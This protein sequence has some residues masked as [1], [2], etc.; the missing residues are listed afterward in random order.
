[1]VINRLTG[2]GIS[3]HVNHDTTVIRG[4][5]ITNTNGNG[6]SVFG[7]R[8]ALE[9]LNNTFQQNNNAG[10]GTS[11]LVSSVNYYVSF[12][13]NGN[14]FHNNSIKKV[15][16][17]SIRDAIR[18]VIRITNNEIV[19][20]NCENL[21]DVEYVGNSCFPSS[22]QT[23]VLANN[24]LSSNQMLS[25]AVVFKQTSVSHCSAYKTN[26]MLTENGILD[27]TGNGIIDIQS[28]WLTTL[29]LK[30]NMLQRNALERSAIFVALT[31]WSNCRVLLLH[32]TIVKNTAEKLFDVSGGN[33]TVIIHGN[34][35][36]GN[37]IDKNIFNVVSGSEISLLYNILVNN[38][39]FQLVDITGGNSVVSIRGNDIKSNEIDKNV[40]N[41]VTGS[42]ISL[43]HNILV[44]NSGFQLVD[45]SGSSF[46]VVIYNNS[47]A[48]N[49]VDKSVLNVGNENRVNSFNIT[50]NSLM[51]N[52][53]RR[54]YPLY[55]NPINNVATVICSSSKI[56][57][58]ENFFENPLFRWEFILTRLFEP[59]EINAQYNWWGTKDKSEMILKIFDFRWRNYLPRL[60]FSPFLASANVFDVS[61]GDTRIHFRKGSILGGHVTD[62]LVLQKGNSPYTVIRDVVIDPNATLAIEKGVQ[63]NIV[64]NIGFHVY[65]KLELLGEPDNPIQFNI[66]S[67]FN[68]F[69]N[70][71]VYPIRLV[72]GFKPWEGIVE[73][74]YNNT[75][76]TICDNRYSSSNG[77][78]LCKQLGYQGYSG[79]FRYTPSS[80]SS[81]PVW[82]SDLRCNTNTHHDISSCLFQGWGVSCYWSL[83]TVRCDPGYWRGIR[84]RETARASTISHVRFHRGGAQIH[85]DISSFVLHFDVLRQSLGNVE[86][87]DPFRGGIKIA[88]QEPSFVM[89]N[90]VIQNPTRTWNYNGIETSSALTCYNCSVSGKHIGLY[91]A[92]FNVQN[93]LDDREIKHVDALAVP[94]LMLRKEILMCEQ[95]MT[96]VV[97]KDDMKIITM[98]KYYNSYKDVECLL[99]LTSLSPITLVAAEIPSSLDESINISTFNLNTS[100]TEEFTIRQHEVFT[101]GPGNLTL[102]YWRRAHRWGSRFRFFIFSSQ[103]IMN[104]KYLVLLSKQTYNYHYRKCWISAILQSSLPCACL[105]TVAPEHTICTNALLAYIVSHLL[106]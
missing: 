47:M 36:E 64:R 102:R 27:N 49:K 79:S 77:R 11:V 101:F 3:L 85:S 69:D 34:D 99:A 65:G 33:P 82:W 44:N 67:K 39:G 10:S 89:N 63:I 45:I 76:G 37:G 31:Y 13:A 86:I 57:V 24:Q 9:L 46:M 62:Y 32:S 81:N 14:L 91:S 21:V 7:E 97:S 5:H 73:I 87:I 84:F 4:C 75:W 83:W 78:V 16:K 53:L 42:D 74:F 90:V 25:S 35:I 88:Y 104:L 18:S 6:V 93:F 58:N 105:C 20:N 43:L 29:I 8:S 94:E 54:R 98:S 56:S 103:G 15:L 1:M 26:I 70:F 100:N 55:H 19:N 28:R 51:A 66:A 92:K 60:N 61:T 40:F 106:G 50:G 71:G 22:L 41:L 96:V 68:D 95:K 30:S 80:S 48:R 72:N 52:G 23:L 38:S 12:Y 2:T 59:Y 17:L